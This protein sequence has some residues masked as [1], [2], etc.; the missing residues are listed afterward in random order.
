MGLTLSH[1][2]TWGAETIWGGIDW[3]EPLGSLDVF[4]VWL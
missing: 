3:G 4:L 1:K 2:E